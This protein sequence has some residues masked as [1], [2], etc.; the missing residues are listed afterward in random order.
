MALSFINTS[1]NIISEDF[2]SQLLI[3][4]KADYV[5]SKSFGD[6]V[7]K[8]DEDIATS[9]ELLRERWEEIRSKLLEDQFDTTQ[10]RDKWIKPFLSILGFEPV[11]N[12]HNLKN[13]AGLEY[14]IPYRGWDSEEAPL[15]HMV[16]SSA[17]FDSRDKNNRTHANKSPHDML[18]QFLN[19]S[20]HSWAILI[21][22]RKVR[23]LRDFFHS[24]TKGFI[25][26]DI[27]GIF[28]TAN[29]EQFRILYRMMHSSRFIGQFE[30]QADE[31]EK[32]TCLLEQFHIKSKETGVQVG[33]N[34]R[35][36]VRLAIETLGNGFAENLNP[37]DFD[38]AK[39]KKFYSETLNIIY[40]LLFL[41]FAEQKGWLPVKNAIYARTY[42]I[43]ALRER[44][45]KA[46]YSYDNNE[47]LWE[48]LKVTFRLVTKGY[49]FPNGDNINAFGGQL[50]SDERIYHIKSPLKNKHLLK[51]ID[52]LCFFTEKQLK[53]KINYA[54]LAIDELGSV[55]ESLLDY[56]PRLL[57]E[58]T[59]INGRNCKRGEFV[60]DDRSTERK[61]TGSY[62]TDSRLVAQLIDSALVPV[63]ENALKDKTTDEAKRAALL[64]LK[65]AD[66][67]CGSGAFLIAALEKMGE[68]LSL[69]GKEE[70]EKP[71]EQEL[72]HAKREVLQNCIYGVD[73]NPMAVELAKFSL[74]IT[75]SMPN[76]PLSFLDHKLKCGNSLVGAT[77]DLIKKGIPVEA[78]NPV[79]LD[80]KDVCTDLKKRVKKELEAKGRI[81][82]GIQTGFD[83]R[84]TT[85]IETEEE[86]E[87]YLHI[88]HSQQ[89][90]AEEV[91]NVALEY[92]A[93]YKALREN[94]DWKLADTWTAAFF[95]Q[96]DDL[97]KIYP[98]NLTLQNI[99]QG[100][101]IDEEL[102]DEILALAHKYRFF[103]WHLEFPEVFDKGGFDCILGN[104]PW[105]RI[106][107][108]EK[109][110]FKSFESSIVKAKTKSK[111]AN[112][113]ERLEQ[114]NPAVYKLFIDEKRFSEAF[115][116]F[117]KNSGQYNLSAVGDLNTYP[118]FL[119]NSLELKNQNGRNGLII[120]SGIAT[121]SQ[122][123]G[124]FSHLILKRKLVSL[125]DFENRGGKY[126][127]TL[128]TKTK[129]CL[130]T[131]TNNHSQRA[132][133]GFY[134]NF[135]S[136][137]YKK[138]RLFSLTNEEFKTLNPNTL[139]CPIFKTSTDADIVKKIYSKYP[140]LYNND[141]TKEYEVNISE[142]FH[143]SLDSNKFIEINEDNANNND[144]VFLYEG[145]MINLFNSRYSSAF[146]SEN[147]EALR[148][149]NT[150][151]SIED[152]KN[153]K[154]NIA[155]RFLVQKF[156]I[157]DKYNSNKWFVVLRKVSDVMNERTLISSIVPFSAVGNSLQTVISSSTNELV[158]FYANTTTFAFD[159]ILR[160]KLGGK[161]IAQFVINQLPFINVVTLQNSIIVI[162]KCSKNSFEHIKR[163]V[164]ELTYTTDTLNV[165]A[166]DL[167]YIGEPFIWD[168]E[169]RFQLK[170]ELDAIYGHLYGLTRDEFD[171]I[172]ETFPIVKRKDIE[173][174][175]TYRTKDTILQLYDEMDWVKEEMEKTKTEKLN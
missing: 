94:T 62:Y 89:E 29:T 9:F 5:K 144:Y 25:E 45:E 151:S 76:F 4:T 44:A 150:Q 126:F 116:Q 63:I 52:A 138:N 122:F 168:E 136:D 48:G 34:L 164:L 154:F 146:F 83:F 17:D 30:K 102:E 40:R 127:P 84:V 69:I 15:I 55:Y 160:Q 46:E 170:C 96:K 20:Q 24:I 130:I 149:V 120:P 148:G 86:A 142:M 162:D 19:T 141:G 37:D 132:V 114:N 97:N 31:E 93:V 134:L 99:K 174:Y 173:K 161:N 47:D 82:R 159:Y 28:E 6:D 80:D 175:D 79:T 35:K 111:R 64:D 121:D 110:F 152:L 165:F 36:Q 95:I 163:I 156:E 125:F 50:F 51:A 101:A 72:R 75:A 143:M 153:P 118:V 131:L 3:E 172:L 8:V 13:D 100:N 60:L 129:Y 140:I 135:I 77:P 103:H 167:G 42:S 74:W 10:L 171:Y 33:E 14:N 27:E 147:E 109:E 158:S 54:T 21:N 117:L 32:Q 115:S 12:P 106:K 155:P 22:G 67:A 104:P 7:K 112:A 2:C 119:E 26:F 91:E 66:I 92:Q 58:N 73:L 18:Q 56:E 23:I 88:L 107:L 128:H 78:F 41:L 166:N 49:T 169:K 124:L 1:G 113:I 68:Y 39:V 108:Q 59:E 38:E 61:T 71:T 85:V 123:C 98:T 81:D 11:Y 133:F 53:S 139:T 90:D 65:I 145:K 105:E 57:Q 137:L 70:G 157:P 43:N 16:H 87:Q